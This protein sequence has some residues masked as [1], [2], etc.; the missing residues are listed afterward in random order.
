MARISTHVLDLAAGR[1]AAGM[2]VELWRGGEMVCSVVTNTD[3]RTDVPLLTG[4]T[5][6][7][8][9]Y[10]L[11]FHAGEYLPDSSF[12]EQI[13]IRFRVDDANGNYHVPLLLSPFGYSI[14]R[15]S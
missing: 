1:P 14:Y 15:G 13:P 2:R 9:S 4:E 11:I 7:T 6:E 5:L 3:G 12:L 10:E 8:G